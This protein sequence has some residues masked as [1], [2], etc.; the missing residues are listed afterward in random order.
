[1]NWVKFLETVMLVCFGAAWPFSLIKSWKSRT[2]KGKSIGFL[3][4]VLVGYVAGILKVLIVD[5]ITGFLL[6]PYSINFLMVFAEACLYFRNKKFDA[7]R[8]EP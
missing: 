6:I 1:M 7:M 8:H 2:A 4:I 3:I 5:G